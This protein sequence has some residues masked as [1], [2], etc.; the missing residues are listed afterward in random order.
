MSATN[1][2]HAGPEET[3]AALGGLFTCPGE[4]WVVSGPAGSGRSRALAA[5]SERRRRGVTVLSVPVREDPGS[6]LL[7][8]ADLIDNLNTALAQPELISLHSTVARLRGR[9]AAEPHPV[10]LA[11]DLL[12]VL[13]TL[14]ES[15]RIVLQFD[16]ADLLPPEAAATVSLVA[17]GARPAGVSTVATVLTRPG[18]A[19]T[20]LHPL[21]DGTIE[22]RPLTEAETTAL[23]PA[24]TT[25]GGPT[26]SDPRFVDA[27][28]A[29]LGPLFGNPATVL[30]TVADLRAQDR[31]KVIDGHVC[32]GGIDIPIALP[33]GHPLLLRLRGL[34]LAAHRLAAAVAVLSERGIPDIDDLSELATSAGLSLPTAGR[35]L[36]DLVR[37][38]ILRLG[39]AGAVE[40]TVPAL[41]ERLRTDRGPRWRRTL[42]SRIAHRLL[43]LHRQDGRVVPER[44]ARHLAELPPATLDE[45]AVGILLAS[46]RECTDARA[47][48]R[49]RTTAMRALPPEDRRHRAALKAVLADSFAAGRYD[50]LADELAG[51][52][53][54]RLARPGLPAELIVTALV[55]W[56]AALAHEHRLYELDLVR[57][58][59]DALEHTAARELLDAV[60]RGDRG[61]SAA[62]LRILGEKHG[63][64]EEDL[65]A[66][67]AGVLLA[68][69]PEDHATNIE[70]NEAAGFMDFVDVLKELRPDRYTP[71][72]SGFAADWHALRRAY[73]FGEWDAAL[74]LARKLEGD[75]LWTVP[76]QHQFYALA[77]AEI[78]I[79]RGELDR[80]AQWLER[81]RFAEVPA[82]YLACVDCARR[83]FTEGLAGA[84]E[85][86]WREYEDCLAKGAQIGIEFL[87][88][89]LLNYARTAGNERI[90]RRALAA[91]EELAERRPVPTVRE[92]LL[93]HGG[94]VRW[95]LEAVRAGAELAHESGNAFRYADAC[96]LLGELSPEPRRWLLE[97]HRILTQLGAVRETARI[98][99]LLSHRDIAIPQD[100]A[101]RTSLDPLER[102][103][104]ELVAGG[105]TN[106][107]IA[108]TLQISEKRVEARLTALFEST[109]RHSRVELTTAWLQGYFDTP[110]FPH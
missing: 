24:W 61:M 73:H 68:C 63:T 99:E 9:L 34:G 64:S 13:G 36:D 60:G 85:Q 101:D 16:D 79:Q 7:R 105:R 21:A 27:L 18:G 56:L 43:E 44:I 35:V 49:Y 10:P 19:D 58:L 107:Q 25:P 12:N 37:A 84:V 46:A 31:L 66:F 80:A 108:A 28:G 40:F 30:G 89:R 48:H 17:D 47:A 15:G 78:S 103:I 51:V 109:G 88:G 52:S 65:F 23:L 106:R 22:L 55:Y 86:G 45:E 5:L 110:V 4:I 96:G 54:A 69:L 77:A 97:A 20:A 83:R 32:L 100:R 26:P 1:I 92:M 76:R 98:A 102:R 41:A 71:P 104:T 29:A 57:P 93:V 8:L 14:A 3:L 50:R 53:A 87:L 6:A 75:H 90:V 33:P 59:A 39:A 95:D 38:G 42:H 81:G 2:T 67:G 11:N 91:L 70:A 82:S 74:S 62:N 72:P 94:S